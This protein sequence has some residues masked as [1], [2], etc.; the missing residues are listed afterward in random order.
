MN[1]NSI[2]SYR[3]LKHATAVLFLVGILGFGWFGLASGED[4]VT[5]RIEGEGQTYFD[6]EVQLSGCEITDEAGGVHEYEAVAACAVQAAAENAGVDLG[7]QDFGF[8]LLLAQIGDE[9]NADDWSKTWGFW[10]NY[11]PAS[12]GLSDYSVTAGEKILVA[13]TGWPGV[14][15]MMT[16]PENVQEG[17]EAELIVEQRSG[18]YDDSFNWIGSWEA[19]ADLVVQVGDE[20][21]TTD[22]EGKVVVAG[23]TEDLTA[24]VE[25][26]GNMIRSRQWLVAMVASPTPTA[27][28]TPVPT[29]NP[30]PSPTPLVG[31]NR[32]S[33]EEMR[34]AARRA[35]S[36]LRSEQESDGGIDGGMV[37]GWAA[38]AFGSDNVR[39]SEVVTG[40]NSL[41]DYLATVNLE[42]LTDKERQILAL[43]A[44][45]INPRDWQGRDLVGE[46]RQEISGKIGADEFINDEVFGLLALLAGEISVSDSVVQDLVSH[47]VD[48][49][50]SS[51]NWETVDMTAA[52][53]QALQAYRA[54][55]GSVDSGVLSKARVYL[56]EKQ[57]ADGGWGGNSATT[58]WVMMAIRALGEDQN[59]WVS[60]GGKTPAT[61]LLEYQ[62]GNGGFGWQSSAGESPFMT[63]YAVPALLG[64]T[65]P[66]I[67]LSVET[68]DFYVEPVVRTTLTPHPSPLPSRG[69]GDTPV[70]AGVSSGA[71]DQKEVTSQVLVSDEEQEQATEDIQEQVE[72]VENVTSDPVVPVNKTDRGFLWALFGLAN[73]GLGG[74]VT[75]LFMKIV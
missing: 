72:Q 34:A 35:L 74:T 26:A 58:A 50:E 24:Q 67:S 18:E 54:R 65:W 16:G 20:E 5:V 46:V 8:G 42:K 3:I 52:T 11:D 69:R 60:S 61:A 30:T 70:V 45:G 9:R 14:P 10:V 36:Y 28:P 31:I 4:T 21:L 57:E 32:V 13:Y 17:D 43:R 53:V 47:I 15:L 51:G 62:A 41:A 33:D 48:K 63:A 29:V 40:N 55:G 71:Y 19:A 49:Q 73:A 37:S 23:V 25:G 2:S 7:W 44:A 27:S 56:K 12:V 39:A 38:M 64:K 1:F 68:D 66:I 75:R 22:A 6:G 59:N